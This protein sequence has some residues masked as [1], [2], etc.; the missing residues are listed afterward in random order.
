MH[1][2]TARG[3]YLTTQNNV[4]RNNHYC[5]ASAAHPNDGYAPGWF[6]W[7][8]A[9]PDFSEWQ[10]SQAGCGGNVYG[11]HRM[12]YVARASRAVALAKSRLKRIAFAFDGLTRASGRSSR[13]HQY[14]G[15]RR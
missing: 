10:I 14:R 4:F 12:P 6:A 8:N 15:R 11:R 7:M 3:R 13:Q 9:W 2:R 1:I 5:V